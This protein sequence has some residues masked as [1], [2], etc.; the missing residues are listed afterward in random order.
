MTLKLLSFPSLSELTAS[1]PDAKKPPRPPSSVDTSK[2]VWEPLVRTRKIKQISP[3]LNIK[4]DSLQKAFL[5]LRQNK[6]LELLSSLVGQ[7]TDFLYVLPELAEFPEPETVLEIFLQ[8]EMSTEDPLMYDPDLVTEEEDAEDLLQA[9]EQTRFLRMVLYFW[10]LSKAGGVE[11]A[12]D[13]MVDLFHALG[14]YQLLKTNG[15]SE[16]QVKFHSHT[17]TLPLSFR[18]ILQNTKVSGHR[19]TLNG[20]Q[21]LVKE[22][23]LLMMEDEDE[24]FVNR[25]V[26]E[27]QKNIDDV[28]RNDRSE[29]VS[30]R[31]FSHLLLEDGMAESLAD[32]ILG[33][34]PPSEAPKKKA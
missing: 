2:N 17:L 30:L 11:L 21:E 32:I 25:A 4:E 28:V 27:A 1:K 29:V 16:L 19:E 12:R 33:A 3:I 24:M 7:G 9:T 8:D 23:V 26:K 15:L 14:L 22:K 31:G 10:H 13:T 20:I 34:C 5:K 6:E 18:T